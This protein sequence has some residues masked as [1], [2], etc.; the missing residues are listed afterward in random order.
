MSERLLRILMNMNTAIKNRF[1]FIRDNA[2]K[3]LVGSTVRYR[4]LNGRMV[5]HMLF[6]TRQ[7]NAAHFTMRACPQM[8]HDTIYTL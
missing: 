2:A 8:I 1:R 7:I 4:M 3:H 5:I 6:M